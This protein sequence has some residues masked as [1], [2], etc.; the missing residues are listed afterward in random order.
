M[1]FRGRAT[2]RPTCWFHP[3]LDETVDE[4]I[5]NCQVCHKFSHRIHGAG[6]YANIWGILMVNVTMDPMG[7]VDSNPTFFREKCVNIHFTVHLLLGTGWAFC[8]AGR[9]F[10]PDQTGQD[11]ATSAEIPH[12]Q[13]GPRHVTK[14]RSGWGAESWWM[15]MKVNPDLGPCDPSE[16]WHWN[17]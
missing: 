11:L 15:G 10:W 8:C 1:Q 6:M 3:R 17:L 16:T 2:G 7:L 13:T 9:H 14:D 12:D 4:I 5:W